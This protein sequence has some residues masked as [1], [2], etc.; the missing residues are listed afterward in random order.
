MNTSESKLYKED[1]SPYQQSAFLVIKE[2]TAIFII[3]FTIY[4][5]LLGLL[6]G[7]VLTWIELE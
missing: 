7:C 2:V 4:V 3:S 5:L 1:S 6:L